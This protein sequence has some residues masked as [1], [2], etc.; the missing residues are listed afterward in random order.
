[1]NFL[2]SAAPFRI[3]K[4]L[5]V[6]FHSHCVLRHLPNTTKLACLILYSLGRPSTTVEQVLSG[7]DA[8]SKQKIRP[9]FCPKDNVPKKNCDLVKGLSQRRD[10]ILETYDQ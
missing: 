8:P 1:M 10:I 9:V 7:K 6:A 3:V 2:N 5:N 4:L